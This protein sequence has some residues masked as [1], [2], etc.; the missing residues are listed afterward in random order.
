M[1]DISE[2]TST[3]RVIT[4]SG[5]GGH[6]QQGNIQIVMSGHV[7]VKELYSYGGFCILIPPFLPA[8]VYVYLLI[9]N[10]MHKLILPLLVKKPRLCGAR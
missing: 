3:N 2:A 7:C 4:N 5:G 6:S 9:F 10:Y 1:T 8:Y